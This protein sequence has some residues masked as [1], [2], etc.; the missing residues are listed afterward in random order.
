M[1]QPG[2]KGGRHTTAAHWVSADLPRSR[3]RLPVASF[4]RPSGPWAPMAAPRFPIDLG[5][6][7]CPMDPRASGGDGHILPWRPWH[8]LAADLP[9]HPIRPREPNGGGGSL[10]WS[11]TSDPLLMLDALPQGEGWPTATGAPATGCVYQPPMESFR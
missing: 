9:P 2:R 6:P 10:P 4:L 7:I 11:T 5:V 3:H 1:A 8:P